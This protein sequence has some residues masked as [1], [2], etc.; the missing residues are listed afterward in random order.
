MAPSSASP[1]PP[2][3]H[4]DPE[5][6]RTLLSLES[7]APPLQRV[8]TQLLAHYQGAHLT[9]QLH[10]KPATL[11]PVLLQPVAQP[12]LIVQLTGATQLTLTRAGQRRRYPSL[13][14]SVYLNTPQQQPYELAWRAPAAT[15]IQTIQL[16]LDPALLQQTA[17]AAGLPAAPLE[18]Q[19]G[20][21]SEAP[22]LRQLGY[23]LAAM[24]Q[25]PEGV[26]PLYGQTVAHMLAAQLVY[27]HSAQP[28][29]LPPSRGTLAPERLRQIQEYV[30]SALADSIELTQ[31]AAMACLS[32]YHFCRL[33]KQSTG[34][35]PHQYV[36]AQRMQRAQH[37]LL[38]RRLPI[39]Q[40]AQA[41]GYRHAGH[42]ARLFQ[43]HCGV[44]PTAWGKP[45]HAAEGQR[46]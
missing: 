23:S 44:L 27:Q 2:P 24:L 3:V 7:A 11:E 16:D 38:H 18:L 29:P 28:R 40:V 12:Q 14:G 20:P 15:T 45:V 21:C 10:R 31:L 33:F 25:A 5:V 43:R 39:A 37:L 6:A 42:F 26:A 22:L 1:I 19:A 35:S 9:A 36:V 46:K 4:P 8:S 32:P 30:Q 13:P 41:V 17:A 34:L